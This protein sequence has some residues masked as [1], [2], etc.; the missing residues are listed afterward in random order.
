MGSVFSP[1]VFLVVA[2]CM[3]VLPVPP[4]TSAVPVV[5]GGA[6]FTPLLSGSI[7]WSRVEDG[8]VWRGLC[9]GLYVVVHRG[10]AEINGVDNV[11]LDVLRFPGD[12]LYVA[13]LPGSVHIAWALGLN[14]VGATGWVNGTII[15]NASVSTGSLAVDAVTG[16]SWG[17]GRYYYSIVLVSLS[18]L[19]RYHAELAVTPPDT[20]RLT[21]PVPLDGD[22]VYNS[23]VWPGP[24]G[25]YT[26]TIAPVKITVSPRFNHT[27]VEAIGYWSVFNGTP[28]RLAASSSTSLLMVLLNGDS[29]DHVSYNIGSGTYRVLSLPLVFSGNT[30]AATLLGETG[31]YVVYAAAGGGAII[32]V[33]T[34]GL[35]WVA[36]IYIEGCAAS[37]IRPIGDMDGDGV[38]ELLYRI[39]NRFMVYMTG[40]AAGEGPVIGG[41]SVS[42]PQQYASIVNGSARLLFV[43]ET[44]AGDHVYLAYID[45]SLVPDETPPRV[46]LLSLSLI[47]GGGLVVEV[48]AE[49]NESLISYMELNVTGVLTGSRW[50]ACAAG[51][52]LVVSEEDAPGDNYTVSV[53]AYNTMGLYAE[54]VFT[55]TYVS[56][57]PVISIVGPANGSYVSRLLNITV[58]A[59]TPLPLNATVL[60]N[61]TRVMETRVEPGISN[62]GIDVSMYP[63]TMLIVTVEATDGYS[64]ANASL[65]VYK[66]TVAPAISIVS[67][68]NGSVVSG[69]MDIVLR[70]SEPHLDRAW[71]YIDDTLYYVVDE[72][73]PPSLTVDTRLLRNGLHALRVEARDMAGNAASSL[74]YFTVNNT[75]PGEPVI[76]YSPAVNNTFIEKP[77][78]ITFRFNNT[79]RAEIYVNGIRVAVVRE[80]VYNYTV[81]AAPGMERS[82]VIDVVAYGYN[83]SR[84]RL[85]LVYMVDAAPPRIRL[86]LLTPP[87]TVY[88]GVYYLPALG[89]A[90]A[91]APLHISVD[92]AFLA[93]W[94]LYANDTLIEAGGRG[95]SFIIDVPLSPG[96][97]NITLYAIDG[98]GHISSKTLF[99]A[100]DPAPPQVSIVVKKT[101]PT[102]A[103]VVIEVSN[104]TLVDKV[105]IELMCNATPLYNRSLTVHSRSASYTLSVDKPGVY[106]VTVIATDIAYN[107]ASKAE[108]FTLGLINTTMP[109]PSAEGNTSS[110]VVPLENNTKGSG[111]SATPNME[112]MLIIITIAAI[113][114]SLM[115]LIY[116][117]K[118]QL[119]T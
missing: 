15:Y 75:V 85:C 74:V 28:V 7:V 65:I 25:A 117:L 53:R 8:V 30:Y 91:T 56:G 89:N 72:P 64:W 13:C 21:Q 4:G 54:A 48:A 83:G 44:P 47:I 87:I 70:I 76:T 35:E 113:I 86:A 17:G 61:G 29:V 9:G 26:E 69:V 112:M 23:S 58:Y 18:S 77:L 19:R 57:R 33:Y 100:L 12:P 110:G 60:V 97:Y 116:R 109:S 55:V 98:A 22:T 81:E 39:G 68:V 66:D 11:S 90:S 10:Y 93:S 94:A 14:T 96:V 99:V 42:L 41:Y 118:K 73:E 71:V 104:D 6:S 115:M 119:S 51:E 59:E 38:D 111:V 36:D 31:F 3:A 27:V 20:A 1:T 101:G 2:V 16:V 63:D 46:R 5:S 107:I 49:D 102:E 88:N 95:G 78:T 82:V 50:S 52:K 37:S 108:A 40:S 34:Y 67:P 79:V 80:P 92:D 105:A 32:R 84:T 62:L 106:G 24:L 43:D 103:V 114:F 45:Q